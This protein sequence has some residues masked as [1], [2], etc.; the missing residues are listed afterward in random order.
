MKQYY[1]MHGVGCTDPDLFGPFED[2]PKMEETLVAM[3]KRHDIDEED[4]IFL[5]ELDG[6]RL[7]TWAQT[8]TEAERLQRLAGVL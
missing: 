3:Y 1:I 4:C 8:G 6:K 2:E 5:L 7:S